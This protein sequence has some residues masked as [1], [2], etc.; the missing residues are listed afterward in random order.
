MFL[1]IIF[2]AIILVLLVLA[3]PYISGLT[4]VEINK[5]LKSVGRNKGTERARDKSGP[6][7]DGNVSYGYIPPDEVVSEDSTGTGFKSKV[8]A[9]GQKLQVHSEDLPI[10]IKL[11]NAKNEQHELRRRKHQKLD[12]DTDPNTYDYDIDDLIAEE[13]ATARQEQQAEFYRNQ[14]IGGEKEE[15]V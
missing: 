5:P 11:A 12:I 15:M 1:L 3:L 6:N 10:Q 13:N 9:V 14:K 7:N 4:T 8:S 2:I